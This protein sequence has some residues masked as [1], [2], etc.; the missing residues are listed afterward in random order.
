[1]EEMN[2]D[3]KGNHYTLGFTRRTAQALEQAGFN[4]YEIET[5]PLTRIPQLWSGAFALHHKRMTE[6]QKREIWN[7]MKR[8]DEVVT[9][10]GAMYMDAVATLVVDSE[11]DEDSEDFI[12]WK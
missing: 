6:E 11:D 3:Y 8:K 10:L 12:D 9:K 2:F 7:H 4:I 5:R 1:M